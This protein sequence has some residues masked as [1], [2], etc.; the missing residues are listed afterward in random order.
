M[1]KN[2]QSVL[3]CCTLAG[4]VLL[5]GCATMPDAEEAPKQ[6]PAPVV[7][8]VP[9]PVIVREVVPPPVPV[10]P[11]VSVLR[12]GVALYN[13]GDYNSAIKRLG[14]APEI[15]TGGSKSTQVEAL[16]YLAFSYCVTSRPV[17]CRHQFERAL[18]LDPSFDLAPGEKGHP[19]WGPVFA[20]AKRIK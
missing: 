11:D 18:K 20:K 7:K 4:A 12:E 16:K 3:W 14:S 10:P 2:Y 17:P 6:A 8:V 19:L 9:P 13:N 15:W 1:K 5:I